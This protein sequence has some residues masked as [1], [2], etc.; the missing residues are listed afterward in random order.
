MTQ[1]PG[2]VYVDLETDKGQ[3]A[4][5]GSSLGASSADTWGQQI[6]LESLRRMVRA[7]VRAVGWMGVGW[8]AGWLAVARGTSAAA[9]KANIDGACYAY[10]LP[11]LA[12][13]QFAAGQR[14]MSGGAPCPAHIVR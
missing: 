6:D 4:A 14:R 7:L 10:P 5:M 13:V 2:L 1:V 12:A 11:T 8:L 3:G 9:P